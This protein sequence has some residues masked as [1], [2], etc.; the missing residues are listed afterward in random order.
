MK[1][2][3]SMF[4]STVHDVNKVNKSMIN[5]ILTVRGNKSLSKNQFPVEVNSLMPIP[6]SKNL[7]RPLPSMDDTYLKVIYAAKN[8]SYPFLTVNK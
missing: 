3:Y 5:I 4:S 6:F 8:P 1:L 2:R 7:S